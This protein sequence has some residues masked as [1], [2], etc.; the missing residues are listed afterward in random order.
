MCLYS[1]D[2]KE[3]HRDEGPNLQRSNGWVQIND[4][5]VGHGEMVA[6]LQANAGCKTIRPD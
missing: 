6:E 3:E 1:H 4:T 2:T 5:G